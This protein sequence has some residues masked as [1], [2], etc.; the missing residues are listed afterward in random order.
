[1][2]HERKTC[3]RPTGNPKHEERKPQTVEKNFRAR[4][5]KGARP[6]EHRR[7][8]SDRRTTQNSKVEHKRKRGT[9]DAAS[10][11]NKG[12]PKEETVAKSPT[13]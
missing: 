12:K 6:K 10:D 9:E 13:R 8:P 3:G 11:N 1:M 4:K 5:E 2:V 7:P